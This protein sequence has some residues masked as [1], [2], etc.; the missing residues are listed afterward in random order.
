[1]LPKYSG[2]YVMWISLNMDSPSLTGGAA[3]YITKTIKF[4]PRPDIKFNMQLVE[5]AWV[6]IIIDPCNEK[7]IY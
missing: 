7:Y 6:E 5:E 3:I 4:I 1:M 2:I